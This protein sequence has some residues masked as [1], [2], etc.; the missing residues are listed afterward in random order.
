MIIKCTTCLKEKNIAPCKIKASKNS[1]C[2]R[3]CVHK[4]Q[5][6]KPSLKRNGKTLQCLECSESFYVPKYRLLQNAR[7]CNRY[8]SYKYRDKGISTANEKARKTVAYKNWR[9]SVFKRD[10]YICQI[11]NIKGGYLHADH[12]KPFALF[13][14]L[15]LEINNGRT[16]CVDCHKSTNTYGRTGIFRNVLGIARQA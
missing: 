5:I 11:C 1:F 7:F 6:G 4:Y 14:E 2:S 10:G 16:L 3:A 13:P 12:I 15:R 9:K 8:C